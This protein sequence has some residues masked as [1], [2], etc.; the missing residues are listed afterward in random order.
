MGLK[1]EEKIPPERPRPA[2]YTPSPGITSVS[3][4][5]VSPVNEDFHRGLSSALGEVL[6]PRWFSLVFTLKLD[7][8]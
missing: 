6:A 3:G 1:P 4:P 7:N 2:F 5:P 8:D